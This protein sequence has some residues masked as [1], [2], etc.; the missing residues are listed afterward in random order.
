MIWGASHA[1]EGRCVL[2]IL[3]FQASPKEKEKKK[4][5]AGGGGGGQ[6]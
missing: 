5:G 1:G 6:A 4:G 3:F 2:G